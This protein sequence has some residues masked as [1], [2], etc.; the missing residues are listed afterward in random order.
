MIQTHEQWECQR[1]K[2]CSFMLINFREDLQINLARD[3]TLP[4]NLQASPSSTVTAEHFHKVD[5]MLGATVILC[6]PAG[7]SQARF[8]AGE[9]PG[10]KR[11]VCMQ[12][13]N[14]VYEERRLF[15]PCPYHETGHNS[16]FS[17]VFYWLGGSNTILFPV[18]TLISQLL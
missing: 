6:I 14:F 12:G 8:C 10:S 2:M 5:Q 3:I 13:S 17:V 7:R 16:S 15:P 4:K 1:Q 11:T 9:V 18:S